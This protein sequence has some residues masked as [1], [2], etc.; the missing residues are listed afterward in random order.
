MTVSAAAAPKRIEIPNAGWV[1]I[2]FESINELSKQAK[3]TPLREV[4]VPNG[5]LEVRVWIGFGLI[6]LQGLRLCRNGDKWTGFYVIEGRGK[7]PFQCREV[8]PRTDWTSLWQK[9]EKQGVLTLPDASTLPT[10]VITC[11]GESYVVEINDGKHYRT[12]M[13]DNPQS[14]KWPEAKKIIEISKVLQEELLQPL[15]KE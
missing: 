12:Y 2:F 11:D 6:H 8:Q 15:K 5:S 4:D 13:Y 3:W 7:Y 9:V 1:G 14:Q 10:D